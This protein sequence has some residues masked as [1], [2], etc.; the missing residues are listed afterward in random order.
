MVP[1]GGDD[2]GFK[3][4]VVVGGFLASLPLSVSTLT[5][6]MSGNS[7][8]F[9]SP[10]HPSGPEVRDF[11]GAET[12]AATEETDNPRLKVRWDRQVPTGLQS[13]FEL[14]VVQNSLARVAGGHRPA[15]PGSPFVVRRLMLG[16]PLLTRS[17][18]TRA[19]PSERR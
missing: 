1:T 14:A 16:H 11:A 7:D 15:M 12:E 3:E 6:L 13:E 5:G 18:T 10:I 17:Q 8:G 2:V 4:R 19:F 9:P